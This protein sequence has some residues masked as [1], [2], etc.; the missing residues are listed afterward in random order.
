MNFVFIFLTF[1]N[2]VFIFLTFI[3]II[4]FDDIFF[5]RTGLERVGI[6]EPELGLLLD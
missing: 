6:V 3:L 1:M 5:N 2:F 4:V